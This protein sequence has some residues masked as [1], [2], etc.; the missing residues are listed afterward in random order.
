[1]RHRELHAISPRK[2]GTADE[3]LK[4]LCNRSVELSEVGL[5]V[6]RSREAQ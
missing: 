6:G 5:C 2:A 4:V 1:M 3:H